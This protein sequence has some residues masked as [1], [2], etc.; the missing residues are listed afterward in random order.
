ME[1]KPKIK[2]SRN[3]CHKCKSLKIKC[4]EAKPACSYCLKTGSACDYSIKLTWGGR[5]FRDP[6]KRKGGAAPELLGQTTLKMEPPATGPTP[7]KNIPAISDGMES[8]S[9]ALLRMNGDHF[10]LQHSEIFN[11]FVLSNIDAPEEKEITKIEQEF[12]S[13]YSEDLE[14]INMAM[15]QRK[16]NFLGDNWPLATHN[17]YA[18]QTSKPFD[19]EEEVFSSVPA[20]LLPLPEL[21]LQVPFYRNLMHFWLEVASE[22][23]V[24]APAHIYQ[25]NPFKIILPRMAME[26][27]S[28]L[29]T[30][31]AFSA[32]IR[33]SLFPGSGAQEAV[34]N[35]LL[36]RSCA[37]LL[38]LLKDKNKATADPALATVL[39]LSCYE[40]YSSR[41]FDKH[42]VHILGARQIVKARTSK[43]GWSRDDG[44]VSNMGSEG[45]ITFFLMR[46][47]VYIDIIGAL[48]ATKNS[49]NYLASSGETHYEPAESVE[50][51]NKQMEEAVKD[52]KRD[53]DHLLG[54]DVKFLPFFSR[55]ALLIRRT[56]TYLSSPGASPDQIPIDIITAALEIKDSLMQAYEAGEKRR[57]QKLDEII[58]TKIQEK[59]QNSNSTSPP[60]L[61]NLIQQDNIL[62]STNKMFCYTGIINL[63]RR[64][65]KIPRN[66]R[67]VQDLAE[68]IA[69][70]GQENIEPQSPADIC[71]I[72]CNFT[73]GCETM[74]KEHRSYFFHKF[75]KLIEM[76]N[77]NALKGFEIMKR[78]WETGEDWMDASNYLDIDLALL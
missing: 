7:M 19:E 58:D 47:F 57:Q 31:L 61:N 16:S 17:H 62:R 45:D 13:N 22:H 51:A 41:D 56:D 1:T 23:L 44:H 43:H 65:L 73:A 74:N 11:N 63:Y 27:P 30:L 46:W 64:V 10:Q 60:N 15:P 39:L 66:S 9:N 49:H 32:S 14:R 33:S 37:E 69:D 54:F 78:C 25:E 24:P 59:K 52:P 38:K 67:L 21:L 35:Q 50:Y 34:I 77:G 8:L 6:S 53:I 68:S 71:S 72:F 26:F 48:S 76:G 36:S 28:I 20:Q 29:T 2:R 4:D 18:F 5:P 75:T 55:I 70:I 42:R 12:F 3:G 40:V